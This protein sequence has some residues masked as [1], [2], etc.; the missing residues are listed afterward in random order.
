MNII[1]ST[2]FFAAILT[3]SLQHA[4]AASCTRPLAPFAKMMQ[5]RGSSPQRNDC[6]CDKLLR[7]L[8]ATL[9]KQ[10]RLVAACGLRWNDGSKVN[11]STQKASLDKYTHNFTDSFVWQAEIFITG[12]AKL[13]GSFTLDV[14]D[15]LGTEYAT[16]AP[17]PPLIDKGFRGPLADELRGLEFIDKHIFERF[18]ASLP[19]SRCINAKATIEISGI[20]VMISEGDDAGASPNKYKVLS[21][22]GFKPCPAK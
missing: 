18:H 14:N 7:N 10:M 3:F 20:H 9:P 12:T 21:M 15:V 19:N 5:Q 8:Q 13:S 16:L 6:V 17:T 11:L 22:D 2:V 1:K 4:V